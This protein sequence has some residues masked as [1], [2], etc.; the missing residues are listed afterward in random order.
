M[1]KEYYGFSKN[2]FD[3]QSLSVKDA[4]HSKD[5]KETTGRLSYLNGTRGIGVFTAAPGF[6]KTYALRCF[7]QALDKNL[8]E[9]AY[10][11]L[12]TVSVTEFYR[13]LCAA[14]GIDAAYGKPAMFRA[15]QDRLYHL[16][17]EKRRPLMLVCDEAHEYSAAIL[18]DIKMIMNHEYDSLNCF[19]LVLAGEPHL[20]RTLEK[21]VHEA[22]RQR[23]AI[24]YTFS[25][26]SDSETE[27]Y[28][29]HKLRI[30]GAA[31][32][33]LGEGSIAAIVGYA[34]GCPR[35]LDNLMTEAFK[36]GAQLEKPSLDTDTI[37]A[38]ANS[39]ALA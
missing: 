22:L 13:Q 18:K 19:T 23:V 27:Q 35:I 2:P 37:M 33:V 3:K 28:L 4:F 31:E 25:G 14:F 12:S 11:C 39:L 16:F 20:N 10:I 21:P 1:F 24:H 38:A 34:H 8:N 26:L 36:L 9:I 29:L 15:I 32:S 6:G 7:A 17:K 30:A 5:Y